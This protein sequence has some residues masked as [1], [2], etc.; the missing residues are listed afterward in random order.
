[1]FLIDF[2]HYLLT[3]FAYILQSPQIAQPEFDPIQT[4]TLAFV[5]L[6]MLILSVS[7]LMGGRRSRVA[8]LV[9]LTAHATSVFYT[10]RVTIPRT[11]TWLEAH[12]LEIIEQ[13]NLQSAPGVILEKIEL[14]VNTVHI[15]W[16]VIAFYLLAFIYAFFLKRSE[17]RQ[18]DPS[19]SP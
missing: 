7:L 18:A 4:A 9:F 15:G 16:G 13:F 6:S 2:S 1:M 12:E 11:R 3:V 19:P 17:S 8:L 10:H 5:L 14:I